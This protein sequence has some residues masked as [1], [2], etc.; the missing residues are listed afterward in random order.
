MLRKPPGVLNFGS[1]GAVFFFP[2]IEKNVL[3]NT[4]TVFCSPRA[5]SSPSLGNMM[6]GEEVKIAVSRRNLDS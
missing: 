2:A 3:L 6:E 5:T 4:N 1:F